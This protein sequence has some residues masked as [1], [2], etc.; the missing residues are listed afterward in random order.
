MTVA[1]LIE[2][3]KT[4]PQDAN[5]GAFANNH[6]FNSSHYNSH[7]DVKIVERNG[8]IIIGNMNSQKYAN[9][10]DQFDQKVTKYY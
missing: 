8:D 3:L 9:P 10:N 7:G 5:I 6:H 4:C 2:I 1:E